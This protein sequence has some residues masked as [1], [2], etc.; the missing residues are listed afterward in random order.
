MTKTTTYYLVEGHN[1]TELTNCTDPAT[2]TVK[3]HWDY[4][5]ERI[6]TEAE[7]REWDTD[8]PANRIRK[9]TETVT[10]EYL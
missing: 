10:T 1:Y 7:A 3:R 9:V 8:F 4:T 2:C 5:S 6:G